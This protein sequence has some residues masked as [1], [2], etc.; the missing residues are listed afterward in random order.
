MRRALDSDHESGTIG[1][2]LIATP[3]VIKQMRWRK[4][5]PFLCIFL[6]LFAQQAAFT[7]AAWHAGEHAA[8]H[9]RPQDSSFHDKLC[10]LH[11]AFGEVL[12][13]LPQAADPLPTAAQAHIL[14]GEAPREWVAFALQTPPSRAPPI[15]S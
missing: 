3:L 9:E 1:T 4:V 11:G 14:C 13:A 10:D 15:V 5:V 12:G 8:D 2:P 7:H 6:L